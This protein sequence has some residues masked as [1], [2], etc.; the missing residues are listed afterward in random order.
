VSFNAVSFFGESSTGYGAVTNGS[1]SR[2]GVGAAILQQPA[3]LIGLLGVVV[4]LVI[5]AYVAGASAQS[6]PR[7]SH[8]ADALEASA[9]RG[10]GAG[11]DIDI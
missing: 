3:T 7:P 10:D 2:F 1:F 8:A 11:S 4:G 6:E 5:L 9:M